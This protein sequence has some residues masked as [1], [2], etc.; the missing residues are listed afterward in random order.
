MA[1][2]P[3]TKAK[4]LLDFLLPHIESGD[5]LDDITFRIKLKEAGSI[6]KEA[7]RLALTG[8]AYGAAGKTEEAVGYLKKSAAYGNEEDAE[9]YLSYLAHTGFDDLML[10]ESVRLAQYNFSH[11]RNINVFARNAT[12]AAGN[13]ELALSF[14]KKV[15][16]MTETGKAKE[17]EER[18]MNA[19]HDALTSFIKSSQLDTTQMKSLTDLFNDVARSR[20]IRVLTNKY[21]VDVEGTPVIISKVDCAD[22]DVLSDMDIDLATRLAASPELQGKDLTGWFSHCDNGAKAA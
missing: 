18:I 10:E 5:F 4:D 21:L 11:S 22:P 9:N 1:P 6:P 12:Y 2:N 17:M 20:C 19:Q 8:F 15:V 13:A 16:A 14:G 7:D 3:Q